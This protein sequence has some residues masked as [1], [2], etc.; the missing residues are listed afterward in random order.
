MWCSLTGDKLNVCTHEGAVW[1]LAALSNELFASGSAD[2][3]VKVWNATGDGVSTFHQPSIVFSLSALPNGLLAVGYWAKDICLL[4]V[5]SG[6]VLQTIETKGPITEFIHLSGVLFAGQMSG[7][8]IWGFDSDFK[9]CC[10][11][12]GHA[13]AALENDCLATTTGFHVLQ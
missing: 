11:F 1:E 3:T 12:D 6:R 2:R 13:V 10:Y 7:S 9:C 4:D 8:V 5:S